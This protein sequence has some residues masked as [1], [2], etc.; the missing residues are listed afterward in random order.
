[1]HST[2]AKKPFVFVLMPF[3]SDF[4]DIYRY[5]IKKACEDHGCYCERVDE[6]MF[7]GTILDRIYNQITKADVVVADMTGR[8][9]NVFYETGY[10]HA[11]G[12]R[13]VLLTQSTDDIPFDLKHYTHLVYNGRISD[14][15]QQL[16]PRIAWTISEAGMLAD[17]TSRLIRYSVQGVQLDNSV[18]VDIVEHFDEDQRCLVRI[19]QLDIWNDSKKILKSTEFDIGIVIDSFTGRSA[20]RLEDG[21]YWHVVTGIPDIFSGSMRSVRIHLEIPHGVDH[22]RL[23]G[24]GVAVALKEISAFGHRNINFV[25]RL[26]TRESVEHGHHFNPPAPGSA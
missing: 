2:P 1:M 10:A 26:R 5:G 14:L 16:G 3:S 18:Q 19:L 4:D 9:A 11:L 7:D 22:A 25:A 23:T 13:V 20:S 21:R 6:Q 17:D 15:A 12:K 24:E 8:N